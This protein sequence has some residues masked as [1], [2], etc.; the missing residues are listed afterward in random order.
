[1]GYPDD[2]WDSMWLLHPQYTP[3]PT[4][5]SCSCLRYIL[6]PVSVLKYALPDVYVLFLTSAPVSILVSFAL[7]SLLPPPLLFYHKVEKVDNMVAPMCL[8]LSYS[9]TRLAH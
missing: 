9:F 4:G 6:F 1:M 3:L 2:I 8:P 5:R 7:F